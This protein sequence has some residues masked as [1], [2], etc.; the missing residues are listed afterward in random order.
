M[1]QTPSTRRDLFALAW[2]HRWSLVVALVL[3]IISTAAALALPQGVRLLVD[4]ALRTRGALDLNRLTLGL[5]LLA[6]IRGVT[7]LAG[8]WIMRLTADR[9][10]G[11]LRRRVYQ[12]LH[13]QRLSALSRFPVADLASRLGP[14]ADVVRFGVSEVW[15]HGC[16]AVLRLLGAI[17]LLVSINWRFALFIC[18]MLLV[19]AVIVRALGALL[20]GVA[21]DAQTHLARSTAIAEDALR[22]IR[23]VRVFDATRFELQRYDL[24]LRNLSAAFRRG[25]KL[26][27]TSISVQEA[28][29]GSVLVALFWWGGRELLAGRLSAGALVASL[30][31][32]QNIAAAVGELAGV[33]NDLARAAGASDR[34]FDLLRLDDREGRGD[35]ALAPL[36][37]PLR[38]DIVVEHVGFAYGDRPVL[39]D[40]SFGARAGQKIALVGGSGAGKTTLLNLLAR[41]EEPAAGR[42]VIDGIDVR[43]LRVDDVRAN[44]A[45]VS[46]DCEL[47][48]GSVADNIRYGRRTASDPDVEHAAQ[49]AVAHDFVTAMAHCYDTSVGEGGMF[50]SGGQRQ[51]IAI[52]RAVIKNAPILLL[53]EPT[54]A[55]DTGSEA[56]VWRE[57]DRY[58]ASRRLTTIVSAHRL[59]TI[60]DA[61]LIL[62]L[63]HGRIVERGTHDELY[64]VGGMYYDLVNR[65]RSDPEAA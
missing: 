44:V 13:T 47:F 27:A 51:R 42:I 18:L 19:A 15:V 59:S 4:G 63:A 6:L 53:D 55:L 36:G 39:H 56:L 23:I 16:V 62:V 43:R 10:V 41:L 30:L 46:Q 28:L 40:V 64:A 29:F 5:M 1:S 24:S 50:L 32:A 33:Y 22:R 25:A 54:G 26:A 34:V 2:P 60:V 14:D 37:R 12:H 57:L 31:Y 35:A 17:A 65:E 9:I 11:D 48:N 38:G 45:M 58:R 49:T 52:A 7:D 61:D 21:R 8:I 3:S 20:R